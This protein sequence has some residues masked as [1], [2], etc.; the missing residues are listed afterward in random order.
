MLVVCFVVNQQVDCDPP[1]NL[2]ED[3]VE[4]SIM[5][6]V[7]GVNT[8]EGSIWNLTCDSDQY[9]TGDHVITCQADGM[10]SGTGPLCGLYIFRPTSI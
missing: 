1:M 6:S 5:Q 10:W 9:Q 3:L 4:P 8:T 7:A 2:D